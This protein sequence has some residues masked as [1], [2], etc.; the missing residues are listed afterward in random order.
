MCVC[1]VFGVFTSS[2]CFWFVLTKRGKSLSCC[3][4]VFVYNFC[5]FSGISHLS[6]L[7][8][9]PPKCCFVF[10][11]DVF[12]EMV[13]VVEVAFVCVLC[14]FHF[15]VF[16]VFFQFRVF[17]VFHR[18]GFCPIGLFLYFVLGFLENGFYLFW[19]F[20]CIFGELVV[21]M[22][23][24]NEKRS[25]L[26]NYTLTLNRYIMLNKCYVEYYVVRITP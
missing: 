7:Y 20:A 23:M 22:K 5:V 6:C 26:T 16:W 1:P 15:R 17:G 24:K 3:D 25:F 19:V 4:I 8:L 11:K 21:G 18:N 9:C 14:F 13:C 2:Q 12:F 10:F